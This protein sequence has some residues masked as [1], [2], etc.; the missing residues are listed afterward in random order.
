MFLKCKPKLIR[1]FYSSI[2]GFRNRKKDKIFL[3]FLYIHFADLHQTATLKLIYTIINFT[4][5]IF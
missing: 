4:S 2:S 5:E 3:T 1:D